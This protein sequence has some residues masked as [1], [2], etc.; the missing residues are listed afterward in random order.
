MATFDSLEVDLFMDCGDPASCE[1]DYL[2]RLYLCNAHDPEHCETEIARWVTTY[3]RDGRWVTDISPMLAFL[4]EGGLRRLRFDSSGQS[5]LTTMR[6]HLSAKGKGLR[7][8]QAL[9]LFC[10]SA[11]FDLSYNGLWTPVQFE[12]PEATTRVEIVALIT[13]HG[14]GYDKANCAEF[15]NHT[16]H[17]QVN[18]GPT[19]V[20]DH[21]M[22]GTLFGCQDLVPD[23][24]VPNQYGTWSLGRGG[25][26]PGFDVKPWVADVTGDIVPGATQ[27][28]TYRALFLG[29]DYN[30]EPLQDARV[31]RPGS[32]S[33]PTLFSQSDG[34]AGEPHRG[35]PT[36]SRHRARLATQGQQARYADRTRRARRET[37]RLARFFGIAPF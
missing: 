33:V 12:V 25:W 32:R 24:V 2:A 3:G 1:W 21:P 8:V 26:C 19:H 28:V 13:G 5:Y 35:A 11:T 16:H 23:G 6:L 27:T 34:S 4:Q 15:C 29:H 17:F 10:G 37:L 30:P 14:W 7:P 36:S 9:P 20:K 18:G 31:S 22:A